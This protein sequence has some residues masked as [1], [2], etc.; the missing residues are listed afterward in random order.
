MDCIIELFGYEKSIVIASS[1]VPPTIDQGADML[2][3]LP[4]ANGLYSV[5]KAY[6][7]LKNVE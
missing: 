7:K 5:K 2:V 3:F 6:E 4:A 1:V